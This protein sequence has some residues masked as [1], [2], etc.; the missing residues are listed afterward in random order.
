MKSEKNN[1]SLRPGVFRKMTYLNDISK[2]INLPS[3]S[4]MPISG[5]NENNVTGFQ[6][7]NVE[8]NL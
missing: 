6:L 8:G 2:H 7:N 1:Q 4:R 3:I 5:P